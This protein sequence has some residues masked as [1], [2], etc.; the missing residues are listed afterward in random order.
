MSLLRGYERTFPHYWKLFQEAGWEIEEVHRP[1]GSLT[2]QLV[3]KP[4]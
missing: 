3:A 4:I 2:D 1:L